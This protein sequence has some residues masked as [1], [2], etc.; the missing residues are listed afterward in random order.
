MSVIRAANL[1]VNNIMNQK[2]NKMVETDAFAR[3]VNLP[4]A[5]VSLTFDLFAPKLL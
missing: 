1:L 4:L 5:L 2:S 3:C